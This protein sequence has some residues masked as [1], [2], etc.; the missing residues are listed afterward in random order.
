MN[1]LTVNIHLL[2]ISFYRPNKNRFKILIEEDI[3]PSD[4][5]AVESQVRLHGYNPKEAI[6]KIRS[7]QGERILYH[8]DIIDTIN[9]HGNTIA[10]IYLGGVNYLTGQV[11]NMK[12][13]TLKGKNMDQ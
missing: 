8:K 1:A 4:L 10:T 9:Q 12:A 6:I 7:R 5:Y 3:F 2:L 11:L 13:I